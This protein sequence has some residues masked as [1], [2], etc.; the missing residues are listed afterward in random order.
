MDE[1]TGAVCVLDIQ[2]AGGIGVTRARTLQSLTPRSE[3]A[4]LAQIKRQ[5]IKIQRPLLFGGDGH[6]LALHLRVHLAINVLEASCLAA[7][8]ATVINDFIVDLSCGQINQC[9]WYPPRNSGFRP[10][11]PPFRWLD[12]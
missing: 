10:R 3:S 12:E 1:G 7:Q 6:Q 5:E 11:S 9:Q 2:L 4:H 8:G